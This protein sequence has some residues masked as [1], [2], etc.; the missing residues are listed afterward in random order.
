MTRFDN[1]IR[2]L[3][4]YT[5]DREEAIERALWEVTT[6]LRAD[7]ATLHLLD[8]ER[9]VLVL[10]GEIGLPEE[11]LPIVKEIPLGKG[12]AGECAKTGQP[13]TI[14]N[15]QTDDSGVARPGARKTGVQS[16]LCVPLLRGDEVVGTLGVGR[17]RHQPFT[18]SEQ[19]ELELAAAVFA[20]ELVPETEARRAQPAP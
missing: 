1:L 2:M 19:D 10:A 20:E 6:K 18:P 8:R 16:S 14:C 4:R 11:L 17:R 12:I 13:V 7:T 15:L 9:G 3:L 5:P